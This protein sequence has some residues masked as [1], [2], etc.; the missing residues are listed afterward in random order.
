MR[1]S[2]KKSLRVLL[3]GAACLALLSGCGAPAEQPAASAAQAGAEIHVKERDFKI[4]APSVIPAGTVDLGVYNEGPVA[5]ELIVVRGTTASLPQRAD[6]LAVDE[7][8]I[9][10]RTAGTLE[11][12]QAGEHELQVSLTPG[13]Y[14]MFCNMSGHYAGGM[15]TEVTVR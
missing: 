11:P 9:E 7:D 12:Q 15:H 8:A 10:Q 2:A 4:S 3:C 1:R 6:G 13:R 14:V 5:H